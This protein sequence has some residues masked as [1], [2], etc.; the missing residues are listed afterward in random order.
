MSSCASI[1]IYML[2]V[3]RLVAATQNPSSLLADLASMLLSNLTAFPIAARALLDLRIPLIPLHSPSS[4]ASSTPTNPKTIP[5]LTPPSYYAP[6]SRCMT[7]SPPLSYPIAEPLDVSAVLALVDV[8]SRAA[9]TTGLNISTGDTDEKD[10]SASTE[11]NE[12]KGELHFLASVFANISV[13]RFSAPGSPRLVVSG[14][15]IYR[16]SYRQ[17]GRSSS[18]LHPQT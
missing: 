3:Y 16:E 11:P 8:F 6:Q 13:V 2:I 4:A 5:Q 9:R 7:S 14:G 15:L 18:N 10:A 17:R 12:W 1:N